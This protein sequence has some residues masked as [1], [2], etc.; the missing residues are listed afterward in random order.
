MDSSLVANSPRD[1]KSSPE[2]P[3]SQPSTSFVLG[4]RRNFLQN[5]SDIDVPHRSDYEKKRFGVSIVATG[6]RQLQGE[7]FGEKRR[8]AASLRLSRSVS[9]VA[10]ELPD[11]ASRRGA[12]WDH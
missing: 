12:R 5:S 10:P 2:P 11:A 1:R 4:S 7:I 6:A 8:S 9:A 3:F